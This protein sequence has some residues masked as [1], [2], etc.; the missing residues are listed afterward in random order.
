MVSFVNITLFW[1]FVIPFAIF[2]FLLISNKDRLSRIFDEKILHRL[3]ANDASMPISIRNMVF[4]ISIFLMIVA[5]ARPVIEKGDKKV[6]I[7]GLNMMI[8]LDISTSMSVKDVYPNR[9]EFAKNKIIEFLK[10]T[11]SDEIALVAFASNSFMLAPMSSDK[12][13]L[14]DIIKRVDKRYISMG[15]T[16][17]TSLGEL[18]KEVL[19]KSKKRILVLF[20]DGG[21]K[22]NL[23][24]F[25]DI[26]KEYNI[27]LYTVLIGTKKGGVV[28]DI[29]GKKLKDRDGNIAFSQRN[30][31]L[32]ELSLSSDG[33]Y[34]VASNGDSGIKDL[35]SN[36]KHSN[37]SNKKSS[38]SIKDRVEL[39]YYPLGLALIFLLIS[40]S[41]FPT[42]RD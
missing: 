3:R 15:S 11:P 42:K 28:L 22:E 34:I 38:V 25:K 21:E 16:N 6:E 10:Y 30:D 7:E 5:L 24:G 27:K 32:G 17:F 4:L 33:A 9:L 35:I 8:A 20:S 12:A 2:S 19:D 41:S 29:N 26:L 37:K 31:D 23:E 18:S 40:F 14:S 1:V 13:T 36:I 39:F